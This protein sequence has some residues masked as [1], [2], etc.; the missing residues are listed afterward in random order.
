MYEAS[1]ERMWSQSLSHSPLE[2][3]SVSAPCSSVQACVCTPPFSRSASAS[4]LS[5]YARTFSTA[6]R[7]DRGGFGYISNQVSAQLER[8]VATISKQSL[9]LPPQTLANGKAKAGRYGTEAKRGDQ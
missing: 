2:R 7:V 1:L 6:L 5:W 4:G 9:R 3:T 8:M